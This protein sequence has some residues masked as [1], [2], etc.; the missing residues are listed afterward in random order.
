MTFLEYDLAAETLLIGE[1]TKKGTYRPVI[2]DFTAG[3]QTYRAIPYSVAAGAVREHLGLHWDVPV[4]AAGYLCPAG[5]VETLVVAPRDCVTGVSKLPIT[6]EFLSGV[7]GKLFVLVDDNTRGLHPSFEMFMGG[8]R[9]KGLGL[10]KL[11]QVG[12][13]EE[14][15]VRQG[16]LLTRIP[17]EACTH[18]GIEPGQAEAPVY[19]YLLKPTSETGGVYVRSLFE[20]SQVRG[21][22][23]LV[24][25]K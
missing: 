12:V 19:G 9:Y 20:G 16:E 7:R 1:R 6:I 13:C 18:F 17:E 3:A 23:F 2:P 15:E 10:C 14:R 4:H 11:E 21:Y 8:M 5:I 24:E 22:T 25:R